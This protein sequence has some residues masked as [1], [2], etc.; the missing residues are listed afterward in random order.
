MTIGLVQDFVTY[1]GCC[2]IKNN[3]DK[4]ENAS[5]DLLG[6]R[7]ID[8][9]LLRNDES[10]SVTRTRLHLWTPLRLTL[11]RIQSNGIQSIRS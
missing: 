4:N 1:C 8:T 10:W 11:K 3:H 5:L 9:Q 6:K 2:P 7:G